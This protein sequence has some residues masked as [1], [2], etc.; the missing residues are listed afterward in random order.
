[1]YVN[2]CIGIVRNR[3]LKIIMVNKL[4]TIVLWFSLR[5]REKREAEKF[6]KI[7]KYYD[8]L[9]DNEI[10]S[11]DINLKSRYDRS[12]N[13]FTFFM[14]TILLSLVGGI[15][16]LFG[17]ILNTILKNYVATSKEFQ[18]AIIL[19]TMIYISFILIIILILFANI[20]IMYDYKKRIYTVREVRKKR[21][22]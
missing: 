11:I 17:S 18:I 15:T 3:E 8:R 20:Q 21:N 4:R 10:I 6:K 5:E 2:Y 7:L 1:M 14:V 22:V 12:K 9:S 13:I 16:G 19:M